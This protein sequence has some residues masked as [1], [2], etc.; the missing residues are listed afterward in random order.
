MI[1]ISASAQSTW[2]KTMYP[3]DQAYLIDNQN[4]SGD[5]RLFSYLYGKFV[6][7][8]TYYSPYFDY[9]KKYY[10]TDQQ[11]NYLDSIEINEMD[12]LLVS[13][14]RY[15]TEQN[16]S[17]LLMGSLIDTNT[18]V[19]SFSLIWMDQDLSIL[20]DSS[21][22]HE[23]QNNVMGR[24][25][26]SHSNTIVFFNAYPVE[27]NPGLKGYVFWEF[28]FNGNEISH[29]VD[30]I[31]SSMFMGLIDSYEL[32]RY[33][34]TTHE[35]VIHFD[36]NFEFMDQY[37]LT[38]PDF[39]PNHAELLNDSVLLWSGNYIQPIAPPFDIDLSRATTNL[40]GEIISHHFFGVPDTLDRQPQISIIDDDHYLIGGTKNYD[41]YEDY[42]WI[43]LYKSDNSGEVIYERY[44]GGDAFYVLNKLEITA[45]GGFL[46][47][48]SVTFFEP[49]YQSGIIIMKVDSNGLLTAINEELVQKNEAILPYPNPGNDYVIFESS[50]PDLNLRL[51]EI[52]GN[53]IHQEEF[54]YNILV[55][56]GHYKPGTYTYIISNGLMMVTS[57]KWIK[58]K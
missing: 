49:V 40:Q 5:Y 9:S 26:I 39:E 53:L 16:D 8:P 4:L 23:G 55:E 2:I 22:A 50:M 37:D 58:H 41:S 27:G 7:S 51:L 54:D 33:I 15:V 47:T 28:S 18:Y 46:I 25:T 20:K 36:Y 48:G 17:I 11:F 13:P 31:N 52:N 43:S 12:G 44:Y 21:Y 24:S 29:Q 56:T 45:D 3:G 19:E 32:N 6:P 57:G 35:E 42:S 30:T 38:I 34:I 1:G 10:I 14:L